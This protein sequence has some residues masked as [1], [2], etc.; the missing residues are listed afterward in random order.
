MNRS[1][2]ILLYKIRVEKLII[3]INIKRIDI[4]YI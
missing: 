4:L 3:L 2:E 1:F